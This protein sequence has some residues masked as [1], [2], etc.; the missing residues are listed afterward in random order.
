MQDYVTDNIVL[1]CQLVDDL[2]V[3]DVDILHIKRMT[4][5]VS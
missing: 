5:I 2:T 3:D 1:I 4:F